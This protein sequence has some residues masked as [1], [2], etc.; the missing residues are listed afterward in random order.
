MSFHLIRPY[1]VIAAVAIEKLKCFNPSITAR[2]IL[3][4]KPQTPE[5][6]ILRYEMENLD[7]FL[8][9]WFPVDWD[10]AQFMASR[11]KNSLLAWGR[12]HR[13]RQS[14]KQLS[15]HNFL[16]ALQIRRHLL[17]KDRPQQP[18]ISRPTGRDG[19]TTLTCLNT[20]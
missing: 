3:A 8:G 7:L 18:E 9:F 12:T 14:E 19:D 13:L 4:A 5:N 15:Y 6:T 17:F 20:K 2:R 11:E 10:M 16:G 1:R